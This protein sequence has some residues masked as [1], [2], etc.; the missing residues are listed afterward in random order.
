MNENWLNAT[1]I[2]P[3]FPKRGHNFSLDDCNIQVKSE[4]VLWLTRKW[5]IGCLENKDPQGTLDPKIEHKDLQ[6]SI[7]GILD[8]TL[9][10]DQC[11]KW[12]ISSFK[13]GYFHV[14]KGNNIRES[15]FNMTGGGMKI[16]KL[17]A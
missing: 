4:G 7:S 2:K 3:R 16:L 6:N 14:S 8:I 12:K 10:Y 1:S 5:R 15:S 13:A 11:F 9:V 17:E